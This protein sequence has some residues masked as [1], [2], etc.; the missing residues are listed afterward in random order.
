MD[1]NLVKRLSN[2]GLKEVQD[3][4]STELLLTH[5]R[6]SRLRNTKKANPDWRGYNPMI[7][8]Y[9]TIDILIE[10]RVAAFEELKE[11]REILS[12]EIGRRSGLN[13]TIPMRIG[14]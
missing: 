10:E 11:Q 9:I 8:E 1:K 3:S 4:L 14:I 7:D 6:L 12:A 5:S 13:Q 2:N